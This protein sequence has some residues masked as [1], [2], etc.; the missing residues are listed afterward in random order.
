MG[1]RWSGE[2]GRGEGLEPAVTGGYAGG[3]VRGNSLIPLCPQQNLPG[4]YSLCPCLLHDDTPKGDLNNS[5]PAVSDNGAPFN[6]VSNAFR[7]LDAR[8]SLSLCVGDYRGQGERA[9]RIPL[10]GRDGGQRE[11]RR[12]Y[13]YWAE[14]VATRRGRLCLAVRVPE[15][16]EKRGCDAC[17][18]VHLS[19]FSV[20]C[21][22]PDGSSTY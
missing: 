1:R 6:L 9:D 15:G 7:I 12:G 14:K 3:S 8:E 21:H 11:R 16:Y 13:F 17:E 10:K 22:L 4:F 20:A 2:R 18:S 19:L 5:G